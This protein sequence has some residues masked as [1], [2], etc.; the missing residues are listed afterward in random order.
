MKHTMIQ[1]WA[2]DHGYKVDRT[3]TDDGYLYT[4]ESVDSAAAGTATSVF[5]TAKAV[6]N[7]MTDGRWIAHQESYVPLEK[8]EK[9]GYL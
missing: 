7:H 8:E 2:K 5:D 6:F 3:K 1:K 9:W 4:W